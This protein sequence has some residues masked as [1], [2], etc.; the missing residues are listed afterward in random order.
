ME[1]NT[2]NAID[3]IFIPKILAEAPE[4]SKFFRSPPNVLSIVSPFKGNFASISK[5]KCQILSPQIFAKITK[6]FVLDIQCC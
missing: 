5:E 3:L 2:N 4:R 6:Y 1:W